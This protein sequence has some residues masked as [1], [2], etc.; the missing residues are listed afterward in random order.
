VYYFLFSFSFRQSLI[1][2]FSV[3]AFDYSIRCCLFGSSKKAS[4][5]GSHHER[6]LL[7]PVGTKDHLSFLLRSMAT[8]LYLSVSENG[9]LKANYETKGGTI[10][11]S[12]RYTFILFNY[13][14]YYLL[15]VIYF[16]LHYTIN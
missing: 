9:D 14:F 3:V 1:S 4:E 6:F 11:R 10:S 5:R 8:G 12:A 16:I 13:F 2:S 15:L 7:R